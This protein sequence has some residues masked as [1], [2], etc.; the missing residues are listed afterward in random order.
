MTPVRHLL[1][2]ALLLPA[3]AVTAA[4]TNSDWSVRVWQSD[5]GLPNNNV[6]DLARTPDGYLWVATPSCLARFDG[7]RFEQFP[8]ASF[9]PPFPN[10]RIRSLLI[11]REGALC[12]GIDPGHVVFLNHGTAAFFPQLDADGVHALV[13]EKEPAGVPGLGRVL[14]GE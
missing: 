8:T 2:L 1:A 12:V 3:W 9:A 14:E 11:N 5:D 6:T 10:Q 4:S 13:G 7:V